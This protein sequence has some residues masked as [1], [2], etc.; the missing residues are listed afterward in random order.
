MAF[1]ETSAKDN[2]NIEQAFEQMVEAINKKV[3]KSFD[4]KF[5]SEILNVNESINIEQ[6]NNKKQN[7]K[8]GCSC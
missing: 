3:Q 7:T 8:S 2:I 6:T 4:E 5:K 1:L